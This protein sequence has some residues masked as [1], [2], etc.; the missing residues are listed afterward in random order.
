MYVSVT[1]LLYNTAINS[2]CV[3]Y[4]TLE[5]LELIHGTER[6]VLDKILEKRITTYEQHHINMFV[7]AHEEGMKR[8]QENTLNT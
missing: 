8:W 5:Y 4:N 3:V 7:A 6:E 2:V 1:E